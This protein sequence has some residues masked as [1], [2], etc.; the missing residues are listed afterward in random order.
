MNNTS[1]I[2]NFDFLSYDTTLLFLR[3]LMYLAKIDRNFDEKESAYI[4]SLAD[5][6][7][8][9][10]DIFLD[11]VNNDKEEKILSDLENI[12]SRRL[13][14]ELIKEMCFLSHVDDEVSE[15]EISFIAKCGE[16]MKVEPEKIEQISRWVIDKIVWMEEAKIIFED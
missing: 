16:V 15:E 10:E 6:N 5:I 4:K 2:R 1:E 3:A 9:P 11:I 14:L 13:A 8:I 7:N 12:P